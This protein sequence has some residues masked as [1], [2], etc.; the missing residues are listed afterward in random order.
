MLLPK[1]DKVGLSIRAINNGEGDVNKWMD[2]LRRFSEQEKEKIDKARPA[3]SATEIATYLQ[4]F[5]FPIDLGLDFKALEI[6]P[7]EVPPSILDSTNGHSKTAANA[8]ATAQEE[9]C[10]AWQAKTPSLKPL[11]AIV[12]PNY[13]WKDPMKLLC[14]FATLHRTM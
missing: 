1:R 2:S 4:T 12:P 9:R 11:Q 6:I 8:D 13:C 7:L 3:S 14:R 10:T 5:N